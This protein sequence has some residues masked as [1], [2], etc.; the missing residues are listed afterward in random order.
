LS[1]CI[2]LSERYQT[3]SQ[4]AFPPGGILNLVPEFVIGAAFMIPASHNW[5]EKNSSV[6]GPTCKKCTKSCVNGALYIDSFD[7]FKCYGML[8]ENVE[9][10]SSVGYANVCGKCLVGIP[11]SH[12]NHV[13]KKSSQ[14]RRKPSH[15][16]E[17]HKPDLFGT[18]WISGTT[19]TG[20]AFL[21]KQKV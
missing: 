1:P 14:K 15:N 19:F 20:N 11:C 9:E 2:F 4:S 18:E 16:P 5:D 7:R 6:T 12:I 17:L 13:A 8:L 10:F 21:K 3:L